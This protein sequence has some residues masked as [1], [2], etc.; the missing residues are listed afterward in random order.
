[1]FEAFCLPLVQF[2]QSDMMPHY[3]IF[4]GPMYEHLYM[5]ETEIYTDC[6][7]KSSNTLICRI[8]GT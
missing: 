6:Q 4:K 5:S 3:T 1:M 2:C 8:L 7:S